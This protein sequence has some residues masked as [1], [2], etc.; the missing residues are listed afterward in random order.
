LDEAGS[1]LANLEK[2]YMV[3]MRDFLNYIYEN[4]R[5]H[6]KLRTT[7][8]KGEKREFLIDDPYL[9]ILFATTPENF[10]EY[11]RK[12]DLTSGW[13]AHFLFFYPE[14]RKEWKGFE[15]VNDEMR[16]E[17]AKLGE[18]IELLKGRTRA[19]W[20]EEMR[21]KDEAMEMFTA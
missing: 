19:V 5:Y 2:S 11:T 10:R 15:P 12:I 17:C 21:I 8:K 13:L 3:D 16:G 18:K 14:Y 7:K 20:R 1:L 9:V 6:R 4:R